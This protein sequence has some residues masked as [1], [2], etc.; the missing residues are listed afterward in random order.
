MHA[1][2][3]RQASLKPTGRTVALDALAE[4]AKRFP[5]LAISPVSTGGL[6]PRS[7][8]FARAMHD[9]AVRR[10][11]TSVWIAEQFAA[12][13]WRRTQPMLQAALIGGV[14]Q[15]AFLGGVADHAAL[16]ETV[17]WTKARA[18]PKLGGVV[19]A[20]LRKVIAALG[21]PEDG[22]WNERRDA[23]PLSDGRVLPLRGIRLPDDRRKAVSIATSCPTPLLDRW[24]EAFEPDEAAR[25]ALHGIVEAPVWLNTEQAGGPIEP[26]EWVKAIEPH[27]ALWEGPPGELGA[28]LT[29]R[30]DVWAQDPSAAEPVRLIADRRPARVLDLCAGRGTK[31]RQLLHALPEAQI[32]A[33]DTDDARRRDLRAVFAGV[34]RSRVIEPAELAKAGPFDLILLDVPCSNTGV[35]PRRVEARYRLGPGDVS[36]MVGLQREI[37]TSAAGLLAPGGAVLYATCSLEREENEA[38]ALWSAQQLGLRLLHDARRS[39]AG[40]PGDGPEA[41]RDGSYAAVLERPSDRV[42]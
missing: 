17:D 26:A 4:H 10:W 30:G 12:Q 42:E 24:A 37:L 40:V 31:T 3:R 39:P 19:N 21:E 33:T 25:L 29:A 16:F 28:W 38:Q 1:R 23:L 9:A 2:P 6:D 32:T 11:M 20:I 7:A 41:Y 34:D 36:R 18:K 13:P 15:L 14:T 5:R 35:L 8:A 22:P 27:A